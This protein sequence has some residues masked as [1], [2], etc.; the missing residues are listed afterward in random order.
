MFLVIL[1]IILTIVYIYFYFQESKRDFVETDEIKEIL[2]LLENTNQSLFITGKAGTGKSSLLRYFLSKTKKRFVVLAPTGVSAMNVNGQTVHS[3]F[4]FKPSIIYPEHIVPDFVRNSLFTNLEMI[5]IDE[6]SMV[7]S[8]LMDG[9]DRSLR[10]N[11]NEPDKPFGGVQM[12]FF[13]DLFQLPPVVKQNDRTHIYNRYNGPYFFNA[14]VFNG[15]F[16]YRK[17]ELTHIFRQHDESFI[18]LL[19][20]V[21]INQATFQDFILLNSRHTNNL[22][23]IDKTAVYLTTTNALARKEN[24]TRLDELPSA[25][26]TYLATLTGSINDN[27]E[28]IRALFK[29]NRITEE[30]YE[31]KIENSFPAPVALKL[32]NGAQIMMTKNDRAKRWV[33]GSIGKIINLTNDGIWVKLED[34]VLK[35]EKESWE[36]IDYSEDKTGGHLIRNVKGVFVQF[37]IKLAWAMT[38]HKSQGKTL[39]KVVIPE[40]CTKLTSYVNTIRIS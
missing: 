4:R 10:L 9:I 12:V 3:F 18:N 8:D 35:I 20:R 23:S 29:D 22:G 34:K 27:F 32:K 17:L 33:N 31:I 16:Q 38:I 15:N 24:S 28:K 11:R 40:F 5:I 30:E 2:G 7:R 26:F 36:E 25:E 14:P 37:P 6:I 1:V 39:N 21:R 13:G 19:N